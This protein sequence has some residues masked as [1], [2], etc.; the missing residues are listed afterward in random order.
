MNSLGGDVT[1][2]IV[3]ESSFFG[4]FSE[5]EIRS[6]MFLRLNSPLFQ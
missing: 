1:I 5:F 4:A 6:A 3:F 2:L